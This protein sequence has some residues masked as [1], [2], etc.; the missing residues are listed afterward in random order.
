[1]QRDISPTAAEETTTRLGPLPLT[2][3]VQRARAW[4][5]GL[6]NYEL[7]GDLFR[8]LASSGGVRYAVGVGIRLLVVLI[9]MAQLYN[10]WLY[11]RAH[12]SM[13]LGAREAVVIGLML[14]LWRWAPPS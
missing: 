14:F 10:M 7:I 2:Y 6:L 3:R 4:F 12:L 13:D 9:V 11:V 8:A 1:M 5:S